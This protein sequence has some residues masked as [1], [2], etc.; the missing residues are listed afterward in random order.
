MAA[1]CAI[2]RNLILYQRI[3]KTFKPIDYRII[4][5]LE[6]FPKTTE[7]TIYMRSVRL[8]LLT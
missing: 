2:D 5:L 7:L 4:L 1:V 6:N 3:N 8:F